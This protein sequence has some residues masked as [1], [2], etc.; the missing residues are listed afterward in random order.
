[1]ANGDITTIKIAGRYAIPGGGINTAGAS[2]NNKVLVWGTLEG[3]YAATGLG[4]T[5]RGGFNALGI[6]GVA[7]FYSFELRQA[8]VSGTRTNPTQQKLF[9]AGR[10]NENGATSG[11]RGFIF[12]FDELGAASP[13]QPS[14]GDLLT[15]NFIVLGDDAT[16][17]E[18]T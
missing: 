2:K 11:K 3:T 6:S 13:A 12:C 18:L 5:A 15:L 17:P 9:K 1:M 10:E 8:G 14:A 7:D 4:L 16:A